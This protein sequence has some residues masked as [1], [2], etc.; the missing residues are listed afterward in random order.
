M[1]VSAVNRGSTVIVKGAEGTEGIDQ[2]G[3]PD[4]AK[5]VRIEIGLNDESYI[6]VTSGLSEGDIVL[7]PVYKAAVMRV[8]PKKA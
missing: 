5:Y 8:P 3:A 7:V 1:P 6:E 4:G 2:T